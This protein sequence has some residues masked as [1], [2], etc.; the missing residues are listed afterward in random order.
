MA[1]QKTKSTAKAVLRRAGF[2]LQRYDAQGSYA[3]RRQLL[4]DLLD[5]DTVLDVGAHA[6]EFGQSL[7]HAGYERQIVSLEPVGD[8]YSRLQSVAGVDSAWT[9]KQVAVGDRAGDT[10]IHISGNDGFSSSIREMAAAH[11]AADPSSAYVGSEKVEVTTLDQ[12]GEEALDPSSRLFVKV[13]TQGYESEVIAGGPATL[14]RSLVVEL[15]LGL[16]ELYK[17]QA[18]FG[19]LVQRMHEAGFSLTDL[20]PGFRDLQTGQ[21]LQVDALFVSRQ[22]TRAQR[23]AK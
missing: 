17:G 16:V 10:E 15:E 1:S 12:L 4:L 5:I 23:A 19:D 18:L 20:E 21:L 22:A 9:C 3:K 2:E 13:D 11:E 6:G 14:A 7:R 8:L